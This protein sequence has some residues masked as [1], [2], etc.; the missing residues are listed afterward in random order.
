MSRVA[1]SEECAVGEC[2]EM[3]S[4]WWDFREERFRDSSIFRCVS[5]LGLIGIDVEGDVYTF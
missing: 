5:Q 3:V 2:V 1:I 4:W